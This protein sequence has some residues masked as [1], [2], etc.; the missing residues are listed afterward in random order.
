MPSKLLP[1]SCPKL[2]AL[3]LSKKVLS[4]YKKIEK[5]AKEA[6]VGIWG[7]LSQ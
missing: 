3:P 6:G 4:E 2:K 5:L 7:A 1:T